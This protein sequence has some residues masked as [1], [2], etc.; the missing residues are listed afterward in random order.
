MICIISYCILI[1]HL[2]YQQ[3]Q[4]GTYK[5][6]TPLK[7]GHMEGNDIC[8]KIKDRVYTLQSVIFHHGKGT[9]QKLNMV[10]YSQ[11]GGGAEKF[12]KVPSFHWKIF[13]N[14][15]RNFHKFPKF[16]YLCSHV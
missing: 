8:L 12:P 11:Q 9:L 6:N 16:I 4:Q 7:T 13:Q 5:I 15:I 1:N 3:H 2:R 10:K 14:K